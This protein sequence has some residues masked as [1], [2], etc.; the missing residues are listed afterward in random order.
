MKRYFSKQK[1]EGRYEM[2]PWW[3]QS[4][5]LSYHKLPTLD[6]V[7]IWQNN[8]TNCPELVCVGH[9]SQIVGCIKITPLKGF[10]MF[11]L[12]WPVP[13]MSNSLTL[14]WGLRICIYKKSQDD[15]DAAGP[16]TTL[17]VTSL[18]WIRHKNGENINCP[19]TGLACFAFMN[20]NLR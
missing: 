14:E 16:G 20:T 7:S 2:S 8:L 11:G 18:S 10:L 17:S 3:A 19:E 4:R 1:L 6:Q 15:E 12:L 5:M 13:R 9:G